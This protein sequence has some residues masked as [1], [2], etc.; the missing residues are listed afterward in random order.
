MYKPH[1]QRGVFRTFYLTESSRM[2][3]VAGGNGANTSDTGD[4]GLEPWESNIRQI[5]YD[6][7]QFEAKKAAVAARLERMDGINEQVLS[8]SRRQ[9]VPGQG[10]FAE[11][12]YSDGDG[13]K[14]DPPVPGA[15]GRKPKKMRRTDA[16]ERALTQQ[17]STVQGH[18]EMQGVLVVLG[19]FLFVQSTQCR[20][21]AP[22]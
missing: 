9:L 7:E 10:D 21:S 17:T 2:G 4:G 16:G 3:L 18:R 12:D 15:R 5:Y 1:L 20:G 6:L 13:G 8:G 14:G 22:N 11:S 19:S